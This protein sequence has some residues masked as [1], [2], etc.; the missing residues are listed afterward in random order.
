MVVLHKVHHAQIK[1][2]EIQQNRCT[3]EKKGQRWEIH[4]EEEIAKETSMDTLIQET[5]EPS[6]AER[7]RTREK[8][9]VHRKKAKPHRKL[10]Q[11]SL[12]TNY[13][14]LIATTIKD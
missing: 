5:F 8:K 11:T 9:I 7:K 13:V 1:H 3:Q 2:R 14:E 12:T 4:M 10:V 6:D